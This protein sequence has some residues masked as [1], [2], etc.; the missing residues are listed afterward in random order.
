MKKNERIKERK[1]QENILKVRDEREKIEKLFK[2]KFEDSII[3]YHHLFLT[4]FFFV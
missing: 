2:S 3:Y 4:F 1:E